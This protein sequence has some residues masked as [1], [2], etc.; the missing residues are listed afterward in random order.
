MPDRTGREV[1]VGSLTAAISIGVIALTAFGTGQEAS[2]H[3][4]SLRL[5]AEFGRID[6][7]YEGS[8]VRLAGVDIGQVERAVL[9]KEQRAVVTLLIADKS[10]PIPSDT[11][12][13]IETDGV[14]GEKY[15]ELHPGGEFDTLVS[16]QRI[17]YSQDSVILESLLNQI[18]TRAKAER[19]LVGGGTGEGSRP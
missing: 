12:A 11:A 4:E 16:G 9:N 14:F 19:S 1:W 8:P 13:V 7:V 5:Q 10:L 15:I 17:S 18:V 6:G 2:T 3:S